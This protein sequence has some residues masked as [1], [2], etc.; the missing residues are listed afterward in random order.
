[1]RNHFHREY[2][3]K[4]LDDFKNNTNIIHHLGMEYTGPLHFV[5]F[6]LD[7]IAEWEKENN[8]HVMVMLPGTK[9]VQDAILAD[10][11]RTKIVDIIDVIQWQY[12]KD[13][14]L[15]APPGGKSLTERQWARILNVGETSFDQIYRA[16]NE[17]R[18]RYPEKAIVYSRRGVRF[19]DWA[20][21]MAGGS[22]ASL[23]A[24]KDDAFFEDAAVMKSVTMKN[25]SSQQYVLGKKGS[26]YIIFC[27]KRNI[28]I[29]LPDDRNK[30]SLQWINPS[31]GEIIH[32]KFR[33]TGGTAIS[34]DAPFEGA[35]VAWLSKK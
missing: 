8:R 19:S 15:Y 33:I 29:D 6:W 1:V 7:V 11:K 35:A 21:F 22:F 32:S 26:G 2:I 13:S 25:P 34:V 9:D 18:T 10:P 20:V 30:Y 24:I 28:V 17:F 16:V 23:P 3:R 14:S 27:E 31:T 4:N 5:E 12:R